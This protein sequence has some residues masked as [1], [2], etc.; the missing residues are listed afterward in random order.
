[1]V[2]CESCSCCVISASRSLPVEVPCSVGVNGLNVAKFG[3]LKLGLRALAKAV[4]A[5]GDS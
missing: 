1:M 4:P 2:V 3:V 5:H